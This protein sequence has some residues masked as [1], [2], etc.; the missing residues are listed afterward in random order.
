MMRMGKVVAES[1]EQ[2]EI[3]MHLPDACHFRRAPES[4]IV[5]RN[6]LRTSDRGLRTFNT[7]DTR[8]VEADC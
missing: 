4:Q 1:P 5:K 7:M 2:Y 6:A 3:N 8:S